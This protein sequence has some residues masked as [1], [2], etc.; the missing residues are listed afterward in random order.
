MK[1]ISNIVRQNDTSELSNQLVE[2]L[3]DACMFCYWQII[4]DEEDCILEGFANVMH[5]L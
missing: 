4:Y 2:L 1:T 5:S 3:I